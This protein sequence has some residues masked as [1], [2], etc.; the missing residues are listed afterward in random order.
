M[1]QCIRPSASGA[2]NW[3]IDKFRQGQGDAR[4]E[5]AGRFGIA[6]EAANAILYLAGA[7]RVGSNG[8]DGANLDRSRT[9]CSV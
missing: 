8:R 6:E 9:C 3:P 5:L 1:D 4:R 2:P 7:C